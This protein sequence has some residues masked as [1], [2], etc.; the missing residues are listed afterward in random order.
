MDLSSSE[1]YP[2]LG[3]KQ[4]AYQLQYFFQINISSIG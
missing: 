2:K 3:S 4:D 1:K